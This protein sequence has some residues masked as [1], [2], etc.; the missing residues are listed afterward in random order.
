MP[1]PVKALDVSR[2][3]ARVAPDLTKALPILSDTAVGRS[4][5]YGEDLKA[6]CQSETN[7]HFSR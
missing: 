4:A 7:S 6:Y 2:A 5:V 1:K 3:T